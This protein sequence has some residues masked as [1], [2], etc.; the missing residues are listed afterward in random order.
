MF[1]Q[2]FIIFKKLSRNI[3]LNESYYERID[4][5]WI[6]NWF[7]AKWKSWIRISIISPWKRLRYLYSWLP[8]S[9]S[10]VFDKNTEAIYIYK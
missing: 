2:S 10:I 7:G 8:I 5:I 4:L 3:N 6:I 9:H 1:S